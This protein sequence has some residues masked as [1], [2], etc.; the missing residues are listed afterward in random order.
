MTGVLLG[1]VLGSTI[2]TVLTLLVTVRWTRRHT[3]PDPEAH[4][5]T[6][7]DREAV[8]ADFAAHASAV[9][10]QVSE[11]AEVLAGGDIALRERLR[12]IEGGESR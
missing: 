11:Y 12:R 4:E 5:L 10:R 7:N 8:A 9:R 2:S 6:E 3:C 1:G